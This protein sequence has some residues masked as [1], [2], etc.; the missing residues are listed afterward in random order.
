MIDSTVGLAVLDRLASAPFRDL[1]GAADHAPSMQ[2]LIP[3]P[4][5]VGLLCDTADSLNWGDPTAGVADCA[6]HRPMVRLSP[7]STL[8]GGVGQ[9]VL[10]VP[11]PLR[12]G[13]TFRYEGIILVQGPVVVEDS[14]V[15]SG[16]LVGAD[17]VTIRDE[18]A[19]IRSR[20]GVRE[21]ERAVERAR[22]R[23]PR[24]WSRGP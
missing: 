1:A 8:A 4:S 3:A 2:H 22:P 20:C 11:G 7:H 9:G 19:V 21:A 14:A 12:I 17:S 23:L 24:A 13:G 18:A 10:V 6:R 15:I 16:V 5:A